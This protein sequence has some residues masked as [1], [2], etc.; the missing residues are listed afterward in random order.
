MMSFYNL[1]Y[2]KKLIMRRNDRWFGLN[3][4]DWI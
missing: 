1:A 3:W 4:L 2:D